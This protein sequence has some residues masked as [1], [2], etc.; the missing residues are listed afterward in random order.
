MSAPTAVKLLLDSEGGTHRTLSIICCT[1]VSPTASKHA[2]A[3]RRWL[4]TKTAV[5]RVVRGW[6]GEGKHQGGRNEKVV[7][8]IQTAPA[9]FLGGGLANISVAC[10]VRPAG[11]APAVYYKVQHSNTEPCTMCCLYVQVST[12]MT[13]LRSRILHHVCFPRM[14]GVFRLARLHC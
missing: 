6:S 1:S 7:A 14:V 10:D 13:L 3:G 9:L 11:V 12:C 2:C 5:V 8:Q 4:L